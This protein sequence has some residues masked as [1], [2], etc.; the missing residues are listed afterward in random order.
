MIHESGNLICILS[1]SEDYFPPAGRLVCG[2]VF[3]YHLSI[4]RKVYFKGEYHSN[5]NPLKYSEKIAYVGQR[6]IY[7]IIKIKKNL[8]M[9]V[10]VLNA[11]TFLGF[12]IKNSF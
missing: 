2:M 3:I 4:H 10:L 8:T 5:E 12:Y 1:Y 11:I 7:P 6:L 9:L